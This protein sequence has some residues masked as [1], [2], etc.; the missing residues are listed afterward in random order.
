MAEHG[1]TSW[2]WADAGSGGVKGARLMPGGDAIEWIDQPGS[3]C[4]DARTRQS[5]RDFIERGP[6][7]AAPPDVIAEMRRALS[8]DSRQTLG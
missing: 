5:A 6:M 2:I 8:I 3:A 4:G 7:E 1:A